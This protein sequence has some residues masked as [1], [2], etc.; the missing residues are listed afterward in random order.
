MHQLQV[1]VEPDAVGETGAV[2]REQHHYAGVS[3][4]VGSGVPEAVA[5]HCGL[6]H[7][8]NA[9]FPAG[10]T[11]PFQQLHGYALVFQAVPHIAQ[12]RRY[13]AD[14]HGALN[15]TPGVS[16]F[17]QVAKVDTHPVAGAVAFPIDGNLAGADKNVGVVPVDK[18]L[19]HNEPAGNESAGRCWPFSIA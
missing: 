13:R 12:L 7:L 9:L 8:V 4:A 3:I 16:Q 19:F 10:H 14:G 18:N 6:Q 5:Q 17:Q 15:V 2:A 11:A 1:G